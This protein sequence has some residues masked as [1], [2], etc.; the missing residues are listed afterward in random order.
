MKAH[1]CA[2]E[3]GDVFEL[4]E[5][6]I[7]FFALSIIAV[8]MPIEDPSQPQRQ[9]A[10]GGYLLGGIVLRISV[11][12]GDKMVWICTSSRPMVAAIG[13]RHAQAPVRRRNHPSIAHTDATGFLHAACRADQ[14]Q[15]QRSDD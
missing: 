9:A 2:V 6:R 12:L 14:S 13:Q 3:R 1:L 15:Y 7:T 10:L 8:R 5:A 4:D 11:A